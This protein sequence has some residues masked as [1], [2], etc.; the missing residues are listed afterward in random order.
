MACRISHLWQNYSGIIFIAEPR[1]AAGKQQVAGITD[2][3][4]RAGVSAS[5]VSRFFNAPDKV[6][7]KAR[8]RIEAAVEALGY[9]RNRVAG[10]LHN[11]RSGAIGLVVPTVDN[12]IFAEMIE[13]F[14][15]RLLDHDYMMLIASHGYDL[16]L[17]TVLVR[18]LLERRADAVA[19]VG[20]DHAPETL[21][22][23]AARDVPFLYLWAH[24]ASAPHPCIG[25]DNFDAGWRVTRHL[26]DLGHREIALVFGETAANDRAR[27]RLEGARRALAEAGLETPPDW[28]VECRYDIGA[29]KTLCQRLLTGRRRPGAIVCGNDIIAQGAIF[30]AQSLGR[31]VPE[32]LSVVGIGD[33]R[34]SA[35]IEPGL[36]T[37]RIP[38]RRIGAAAA[39]AV[40]KMIAGRE[41]GAGDGA[42]E[43]AGE[44]L[45]VL[46][47][48]D[49]RIRGSARSLLPQD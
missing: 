16:A 40:I 42:E 47:E 17:E 15:T 23:L 27:A 32:D 31:R 8:A 3:A 26:I 11:R 34:G 22:L 21:D 49:L 12:A 44:G 14:A 4:R 43:G 24:A 41:Q 48:P 18:T 5:T 6:G 35:H 33:F 9:V 36:T 30:A 29:A 1:M 20:L 38:A 13:A 7:A 28:Q 25:V 45:S 19:L 10:S 39:D 2:V 46:I 37:V